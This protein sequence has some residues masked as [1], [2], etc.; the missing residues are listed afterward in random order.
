M[1]NDVKIDTGV[2]KM[3]LQAWHPDVGSVPQFPAVVDGNQILSS[4]G[5][6]LY[7]VSSNI[8]QCIHQKFARMRA[9]INAKNGNMNPRKK[10][11]LTSNLKELISIRLHKKAHNAQFGFTRIRDAYVQSNEQ[12]APGE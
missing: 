6:V 4:S 3:R 7:R 2:K 12:A 1:P 5:L 9:H 8:V 11:L 10:R